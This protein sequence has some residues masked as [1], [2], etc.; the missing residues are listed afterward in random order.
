[1]VE[2]SVS[3]DGTA[4]LVLT[5]TA[6]QINAALST[7]IYSPA[8][9]YNGADTLDGGEGIDTVQADRAK[10]R[11]GLA[12]LTETKG[13]IGVSKRTPDREAVKLLTVQVKARISWPLPP[14]HHTTSPRHHHDIGLS[15]AA[16]MFDVHENLT[17]QQQPDPASA[18]VRSR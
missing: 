14:R 3:G 9:D 4:V 2:A 17:R 12:K 16:L 7:L 11:N 18:T 10:I 5:G 1:M 15:D 6:A 13:L 8:A